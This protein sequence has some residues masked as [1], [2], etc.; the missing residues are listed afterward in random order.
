MTSSM[1][2][3]SVCTSQNRHCQS[4]VSARQ[5]RKH[6]ACHFMELTNMI[7]NS[8]SPTSALFEDFIF[9]ALYHGPAVGHEHTLPGCS[10]A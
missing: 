6:H 4:L 10:K 9:E 3:M 1:Y 5:E 7:C 2:N 8:M